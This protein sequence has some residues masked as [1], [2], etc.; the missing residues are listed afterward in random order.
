MGC[1]LHFVGVWKLWG[2][3]QGKETFAHFWAALRLYQVL[4]SWIELALK[5]QSYLH[6]LGSKNVFQTVF[7]LFSYILVV[8]ISGSGNFLLFY[9]LQI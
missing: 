3:S 2:P 7:A 5:L 8:C 1:V 6:L 9:F 4:K